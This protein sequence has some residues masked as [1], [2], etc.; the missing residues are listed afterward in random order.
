MDPSSASMVDDA[1]FTAQIKV[2]FYG[3]QYMGP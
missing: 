1:N 2:S 3:S